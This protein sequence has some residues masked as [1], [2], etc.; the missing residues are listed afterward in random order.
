MTA[1]VRAVW[2][3]R[4]A[5]RAR[6]ICKAPNPSAIA[7]SGLSIPGIKDL[8]VEY[9]NPHEMCRFNVFDG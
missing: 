1:V 9:G 3:H 8:D 5:R 7:E 2:K 6:L 4:P